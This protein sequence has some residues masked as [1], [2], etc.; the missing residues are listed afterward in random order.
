MSAG[1]MFLALGA[2]D[3]FDRLANGSKEEQEKKE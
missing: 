3:F 2:N 1:D